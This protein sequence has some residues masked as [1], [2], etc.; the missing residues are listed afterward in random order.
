MASIIKTYNFK[1]GRMIDKDGTNYANGEFVSLEDYKIEREKNF[2]LESKLDKYVRLRSRF[3]DSAL[4]A[5]DSENY[6]PLC[7]LTISE[8]SSYKDRIKE[9]EDETHTMDCFSTP[10]DVVKMLTSATCEVKNPSLE[11]PRETKKYTI[12][13]LKQIAEYLLVYCKHN[14]EDK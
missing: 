13:E 5:F 8:L 14:K 6:V 10:L 11:E 1:N 9:L 12:D 7:V 4:I 2:C 3:T